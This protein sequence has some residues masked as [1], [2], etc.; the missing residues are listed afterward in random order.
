MS[1]NE[2]LSAII[3]ETEK[4][5][6]EKSDWDALS[7]YL[8]YNVWVLS[9]SENAGNKLHLRN[10]SIFNELYEIAEKRDRMKYIERCEHL[11]K[12]LYQK[13]LEEMKAEI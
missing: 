9:S 1:H 5:M 8:Q 10:I 12:E 3:R 7:C 13:H 4:H 6:M 2:L 11:Q